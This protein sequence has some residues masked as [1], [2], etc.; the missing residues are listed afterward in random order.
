MS[1]SEQIGIFGQISLDTRIRQVSR[2]LYGQE[3]PGCQENLHCPEPS[4]FAP[5]SHCI[6]GKCTSG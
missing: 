3:T 6:M 5:N 4:R 2:N 1:V